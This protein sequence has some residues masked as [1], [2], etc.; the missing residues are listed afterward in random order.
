[1]HLLQLPRK[2]FIRS[3]YFCINHPL[4]TNDSTF[5]LHSAV[6]KKLTNFLNKISLETAT[7]DP[8]FLSQEDILGSLDPKEAQRLS[9]IRN[10]GIAVRPFTFSPYT[11][12]F[13]SFIGF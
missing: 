9:R 11:L 10:I 2:E 4:L 5:V 3:P 12:I 1:M 6:L 8:E 7:G 13:A